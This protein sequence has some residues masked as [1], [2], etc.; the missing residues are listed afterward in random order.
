MNP[1]S[2][3]NVQKQF[4]L[5]DAEIN[6]ILFC[7]ESDTEDALI[8]DDD[9]IY[10]LEDDVT[11]M[12]ANSNTGDINVVIDPSK[13]AMIPVDNIGESSGVQVLQSSEVPTK[14]TRKTV[15]SENTQAFVCETDASFEYEKVLMPTSDDPNPYEI[16][17]K[18]ARFDKFLS[19]IVIPQTTVYSQQKGHVFSTELEELGAYFGMNLGC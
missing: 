12:E 17:E 16:F 9:D 8:L 19:Y 5:T 7:D 10:F 15:T 14:F 6:R 1:F 3:H 4:W 18:V 11:Q 2:V 13:D